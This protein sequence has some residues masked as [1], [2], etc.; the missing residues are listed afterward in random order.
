MLAQGNDSFAQGKQ[1]CSRSALIEHNKNICLAQTKLLPGAN[2]KH[3]D[4]G[5]HFT[6]MPLCKPAAK[7]ILKSENDDPVCTDP[8]GT[9]RAAVHSEIIDIIAETLGL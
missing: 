1:S 8:V 7:T 4:P 6:A 9:D 3:F 5:F 2:I